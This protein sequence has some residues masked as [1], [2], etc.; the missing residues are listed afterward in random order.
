MNDGMDWN[1]MDNYEVD[2]LTL[3]IVCHMTIIANNMLARPACLISFAVYCYT[4]LDA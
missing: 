4:F 2:C 1:G 3:Y